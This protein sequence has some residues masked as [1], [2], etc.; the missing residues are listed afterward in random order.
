VG[1]RASFKNKMKQCKEK[2]INAMPMR[3]AIQL[4]INKLAADFSTPKIC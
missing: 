4:K 1:D 2:S 3:N